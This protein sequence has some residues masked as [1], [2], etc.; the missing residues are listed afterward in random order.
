MSADEKILVVPRAILLPEGLRGFRAGPVD[1]YVQQIR[2]HGE[3][4]RRGEVEEDPSL[5]QI[6]PYL[7]VRHGERIFLFRRLR[8]GG[9]R[10]LRGL[11]SIGVGGHIAR[12]DMEAGDVPHAGDLLHAGLLRELREELIVSGDLNVR[13]VGV[14]NDEENPVG[15]VHF[16]LV[17]V[18]E[19]EHPE[20]RVREAGRLRGHLATAA[21]VQEAHPRMETWSRLILDAA[22]PFAL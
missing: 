6:I 22:D 1:E 12:G 16:G 3:F 8:R 20:V 21:E 5:K 18:V 19:T 14:L 4:R 10:R 17:Y 7:I 9:E 13:P 11:Y 2:R 15:Q